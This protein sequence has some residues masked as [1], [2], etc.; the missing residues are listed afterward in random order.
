[1]VDTKAVIDENG[2]FEGAHEIFE[3]IKKADPKVLSEPE[4]PGT[5]IFIGDNCTTKE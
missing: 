2:D 4:P 5:I 3:A 1:M